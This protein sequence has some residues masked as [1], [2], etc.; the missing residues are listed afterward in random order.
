MLG[1]AR[2]VSLGLGK[3]NLAALDSSLRNRDGYLQARRRREKSRRHKTTTKKYIH[4]EEASRI[5]RIRPL[6][7]T[8]ISYTQMHSFLLER[9]SMSTACGK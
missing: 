3:I 5:G 8:A 4:I 7:L 1:T 9:C 2:G 6:D